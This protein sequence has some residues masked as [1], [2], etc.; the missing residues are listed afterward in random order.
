MVE[1]TH[2]YIRA[3]SHARSHV[4]CAF[5][6]ARTRDHSSGLCLASRVCGRNGEKKAR[7]DRVQVYKGSWKGGDL[8]LSP[9][10]RTAA[11][12]AFLSLSLSDSS[13]IFSFSF[14][15]SRIFYARLRF[16]LSLVSFRLVS[17]FVLVLLREKKDPMSLGRKNT[18]QKI[19]A[20]IVFFCFKLADCRK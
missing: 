5:V 10:I 6:R 2:T 18:F 1:N 12:P 20:W 16:S 8:P 9:F 7:R 4:A 13:F 17:P 14:A 19:P 15:A 11:F 3:C